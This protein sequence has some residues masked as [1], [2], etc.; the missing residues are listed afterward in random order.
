MSFFRG[1]IGAPVAGLVTLGL[2]LVMAGLISKP[3]EIG[4]PKPSPKFDFLM[5]TAPPDEFEPVDP[6]NELPKE[7]PPLEI[8]RQIPGEAPKGVPAPRPGAEFDPSPEIENRNFGGPLIRT[9]PLYPEGCRSRGAEGRVVVQFDVTPEGNVTNIVIVESANSC[10]NRTVRNAVSKWKYPPA[11]ENG[12]SV[13][14]YGVVETF[15][16]SLTE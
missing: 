8:K 1:L 2:F 7:T 6:R 13:M 15:S 14:R 3:V 10:F 12:R 9:A 11:T 5:D 16:F 4:E